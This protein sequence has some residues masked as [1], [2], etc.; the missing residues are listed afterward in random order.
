MKKYELN[1]KKM[2]CPLPVVQTK[3]LL[4]EYD[5]V[6]TTVDNV[7]ATQ[8]LEKLATQLN[9]DYN[10]EKVSDEEYKVTISNKKIETADENDTDPKNEN[11]VKTQMF[12][13]DYIVVINKKIM[14]HGSEELGN[15]L[16]KAYLYTLSEQEI[17]P[18][19]VIF[20]NEGA[21]LTDKNRSHV[22][23]ELKELE[24]KGVEILCCGI[25]LEYYNVEIAVGKPTN[26][27]FIVED[28]RKNKVV[29]P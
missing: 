15:K 22:L 27:Y 7:I 11:E 25:C 10:L 20:Y 21:V 16:I 26:M 4:K 12:N 1:A 8:N 24:S 6:E 14:G 9:Y 17:L 5:T 18:K 29:H 3:K 28:M 2:A 23:S 19:K 13:D